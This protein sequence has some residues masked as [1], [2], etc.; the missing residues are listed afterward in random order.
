[1]Q[2]KEIECLEATLDA[3][4]KS[5]VSVHCANFAELESS[6]KTNLQFAEMSA[7]DA[8]LA[9]SKAASAKRVVTSYWIEKLTNQDKYDQEFVSTQNTATGKQLRLLTNDLESALRDTDAVK[10]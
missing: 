2:K 9:L 1:M 6:F 3:R 4:V 8:E 5:A 10:E 7:S